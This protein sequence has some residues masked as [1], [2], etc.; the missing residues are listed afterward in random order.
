MRSV[1]Q[2]L[3]DLST[4]PVEGIKVVPNEKDVTEITAII[5]GPGVYCD[6]TTT[7]DT[8]RG[9][10]IR[11]WTVYDEAEVGPRLPSQPPQRLLSYE[12]IPP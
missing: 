11:W 5:D 9:H 1:F 4:H 6:R 3:K 12:H 10:A 2:E 7:K 8:L